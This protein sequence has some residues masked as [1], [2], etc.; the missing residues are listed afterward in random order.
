MVA[1]FGAT[2]FGQNMDETGEFGFRIGAENSQKV[3][4][5][6]RP[7]DL[8]CTPLSRNLFEVR[9]TRTPTPP[10]GAGTRG[11]TECLAKILKSAI[12]YGCASSP[13]CLHGALVCA[14]ASGG[15]G[16]SG[17]PGAASECAGG[18][19]VCV[20]FENSTVCR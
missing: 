2:S 19:G 6:V 15:I 5:R 13:D 10:A 3:I 18:D 11:C 7:G 14:G 12:V 16:W 1:S 20:F 17:C 8:E 4:I 9:A